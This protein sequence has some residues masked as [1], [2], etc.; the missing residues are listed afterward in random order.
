VPLTFWRGL[1]GCAEYIATRGGAARRSWHPAPVT[2][3]A[4]GENA[5]QRIAR[6][7]PFDPTLDF[8]SAETGR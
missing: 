4:G 7:V 6:Q 1:F 8:A 5:I 2:R 3:R